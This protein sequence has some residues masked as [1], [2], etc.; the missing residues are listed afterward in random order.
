MPD[1]FDPYH[2]WLGIPP[3]EQPPDY[4]RLLGIKLFE[5]D[6]DVIEAAAD[7]R[8]A[9]VHTYQHGKYGE[10]CHILLTKLSSARVCLLN[11]LKKAAYDRMLRQK[12]TLETEKSLP[13]KAKKPA[14]RR[15]RSAG[16][17]SSPPPAPP[18]LVEEESDDSS[19]TQTILKRLGE[20]E[21]IEKLGAGGMGAVYKA[22]HIKLRR[23]VALKV[24]AKDRLG[25]RRAIARFEREM[26][27][28]GAMDHPNVVR[29]HDAR[30]IKGTRILVM[31]YV[32][33]LDLTELCQRSGPL[34]VANAC[35]IARQ[36]ALGLQAAHEQRLVHRDV[37][38]SN[39]MLNP[40]GRVKLLDLG[41]ARQADEKSVSEVTATEQAVGTPDYMAP[42]QISESENMDIRSD[43]YGL[44]CTLYK[45]LAGHAPFSG[46][47]YKSTFDKLT[48]H[49]REPVPPIDRIRVDV[50]G[51]LAAVINR[52]LAKKPADRFSIPA[53]V[54]D[55]LG[56]FTSDSDLP[57]LL[58]TA[59]GRAVPPTGQR[60]S[61]SG[62]D[63]MYRSATAGTRSGEQ[64]GG[65]Q[66]LASRK[67][68]TIV[69]VVVL[70]VLAGLFAWTRMPGK[71]P[72][73]SPS[74]SPPVPTRHWDPASV[75]PRGI[76]EG[77][78][79]TVR[80]V[81][82]SPDG[83]ILATGS[84][85][86]TL[87]LWNVFT[88]QLRKSLEGNPE[89]V[90]SVAI[91]P[92]GSTIAAAG[93]ERMVRLWNLDED[94][95]Q[96][97]LDG[98]RDQ[99]FSVAF[100]P[101]GKTLASGSVDRTIILWDA[102]SGKRRNT[103]EGHGGMVNC[104][105]FSPDGKTLASASEDK[106]VILW[107]TSSGR[108]RKTLKGHT[109][110]LT[111]VDFSPDGSMAVAGSVDGS[112]VLWNTATGEILRT[113]KGHTGSVTS[114]AFNPDGCMIASASDDKTAR[115]W[116][117]ASGELQKTLED[118]KAWVCYVDF[119]PDGST[120]ATAS[121]DKTVKLWV[122]ATK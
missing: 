14:R 107:N 99:V 8:M 77:H 1:T 118:H 85:D 86:R 20:Y 97:V 93:Y 95:P 115:L 33:G 9:H 39:L 10:S 102:A 53:E 26:A 52:M 122:F 114:V 12:A 83:S 82:F 65:K 75:E 21:L 98:H 7:Q 59:E 78:K 89:G 41:L 71:S 74:V 68:L 70:V 96:K 42:E 92:D 100:S 15:R 121:K 81:A 22:Q 44:G 25:N 4:Y 111:S 120:L 56:P 119:S 58:A 101:D 6:V 31:E 45:L 91:S 110:P 13:P 32:K 69:G 49:V 117:A 60:K 30:E 3:E 105:A 38:P 76:L 80:S 46:K 37:K 61:L 64:P 62:T 17:A 72:R 103:L 51:E 112:V 18:P 43:V 28:V 87:K 23:E 16:Q 66:I 84:Y 5:E 104:V 106:T 47:K 36:A 88:G 27:A 113:L 35:E 34:S 2:K 79:G 19:S 109:S 90:V 57:A 55:A 73:I 48:A 67:W 40:E 54:A 11:P 50:P 29:A 116:N 63:D 108:P 94:Q 24:L